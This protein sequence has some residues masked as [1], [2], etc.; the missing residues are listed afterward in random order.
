VAR[1][2]EIGLVLIGADRSVAAGVRRVELHAGEAADA[3]V[4]TYERSLAQ[5]ADLLRSNPT[6]LPARVESIQ[7]EAKR[8]QREIARLRQRLAAGGG[9]ETTE[10]EVDGVK[11]MLQAGR[12]RTAGT[13]G[14]CRPGS[15]PG[16]R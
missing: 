11:L 3:M 16:Q 15:D 5:L 2:G 1:S 7:A 14:V 13:A 4:R 12:C 6:D 9:V 8:L 10:A